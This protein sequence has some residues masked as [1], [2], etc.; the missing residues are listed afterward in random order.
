MSW[1][2]ISDQRGQ[3]I[4]AVSFYGPVERMLD[5]GLTHGARLEIVRCL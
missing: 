1:R 2:S 3:G 5:R 4:F